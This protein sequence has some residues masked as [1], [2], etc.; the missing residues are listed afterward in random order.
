MMSEEDLLQATLGSG[1]L[2]F[3]DALWVLSTEEQRELGGCFQHLGQCFAL[4]ILANPM[5]I[6]GGAVV[7]LDLD[8]NKVTDVAPS[9]E[10]WAALMVARPGRYAGAQIAAKWIGV[11]GPIPERHRLVLV[12]P[13]HLGGQYTPENLLAMPVDEAI[14]HC[15]TRARNF[16]LPDKWTMTVK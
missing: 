7:Q 10:E 11:N 16:T 13:V 4:D 12:Y 3:G 1:L 15:S 2:A 14:E 9:L 6:S 8:S 5:L